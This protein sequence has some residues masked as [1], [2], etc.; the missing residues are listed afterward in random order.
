[1]ED[2]KEVQSIIKDLQSASETT[3]LAAIKKNRVHG[4][5]KT[6][7]V[8]LDVL[9]ETDAPA[10]EAAII[11]FL[12]DLKEQESADILA[13]KL[14]GNRMPFYDSFLIAAFWQSA[15]DGSAY[16]KLFVKKAIKG[17]YMVALEALT[18]IENFD[19][20]FP[21]EEISDC[22]EDLN[23]AIEREKIKDKKSLL[24]SIR[25]VI[26]DLPRL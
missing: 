22:E 26:L 12:F 21:E 15:I 20:A 10:V 11:E 24:K 8:L 6:F 14:A 7:R 13:E 2:S 16:L 5:T 3:V 19:T 25:E 1:M 23:E 9:N 18:V 4:N 17:D